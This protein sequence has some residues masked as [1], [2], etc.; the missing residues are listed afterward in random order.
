MVKIAAGGGVVDAD[1]L[2]D[3]GNQGVVHDGGSGAAAAAG[4]AVKH[5]AA[6]AID[7]LRVTKGSKV[8]RGNPLEPDRF[9]R[10]A[11][12]QIT[13]RWS[14]KVGDPNGGIGIIVGADIAGVTGPDV[15]IQ[16]V[17]HGVV[18]GGSA[19]RRTV[20]RSFAGQRAV[21]FD[22]N[23]GVGGVFE[24]GSAFNRR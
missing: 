10:I 23:I 5:D 21:E 18:I 2:L 6:D 22:V 9:L 4:T 8:A 24:N 12:A 11:N 7:Q 19:D 13:Q 15:G 1:G 17:S 14:G 3:A 16:S 20:A